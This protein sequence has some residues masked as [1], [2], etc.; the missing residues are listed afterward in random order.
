MRKQD[1]FD[2][3]IIIRIRPIYICIW[4]GIKISA[5]A[6]LLPIGLLQKGKLH[7]SFNFSSVKSLKL[8]S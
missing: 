1:N 7:F 4:F 5:A 8:L 2:Q 3:V 6:S